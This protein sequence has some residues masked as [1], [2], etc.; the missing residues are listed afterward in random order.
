MIIKSKNIKKGINCGKDINIKCRKI[1]SLDS[2]DNKQTWSLIDFRVLPKESKNIFNYLV[3]I[4]SRIIKEYNWY[5]EMNMFEYLWF[6]YIQKEHIVWL[7]K[8]KNFK[9]LFGIFM[10][11]P[12]GSFLSFIYELVK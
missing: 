12:I 10:G 1:Q 6:N 7:F 8:E 9:Y 4:D 2:E 3:E 11:L 5:I